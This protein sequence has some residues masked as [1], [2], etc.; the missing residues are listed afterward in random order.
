MAE[1]T[2]SDLS[3]EVPAGTLTETADDVTISLKALTGE[4]AVQ[5]ADEVIGESIHKLLMACQRTQ[6]TFNQTADPVMSSFPTAA[7]GA[8]RP[9]GNGGYRATFNHSV[10]IFVPLDL[11]GASAS[12]S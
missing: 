2:L 9:D 8:P 3:A 7:A 5:L 11:D 10:G 6:S 12:P 1:F 4:T